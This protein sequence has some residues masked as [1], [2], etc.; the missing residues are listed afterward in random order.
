M[1][2]EVPGTPHNFPLKGELHP[3]TTALLVIDMQH[4]FVSPG[5][6]MHALG[7][8]LSGLR[9]PIEPL[10]SLLAAARSWGCRIAHTREGYATDLSDLQPW[11]VGGGPGDAVAVGDAGPR[12]R[13][14]IR[15]EKT[16]DIIPELTP[17]AGEPVFDKPSYGAFATT[18]LHRTLTGW[19]IRHVVL[20][21]VTTDCCVTSTLREALD[22]GYECVVVTDCVGSA[23]S[24]HHDA[25]ITLMRKPSGVFGTTARSRDLIEIMPS[26]PAH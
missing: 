19:G 4:D 17:I 10:K 7:V 14:L 1:S 25:A 21:G 23:N 16:A 9:A 5:G 18:D 20:T 15:G 24:A 8:N 12:G 13:F 2:L 6:Y 3:K 11:K 22:R 26:L